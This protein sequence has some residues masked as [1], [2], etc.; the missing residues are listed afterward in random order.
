MLKR[1]YPS[2]ERALVSMGAR[3]LGEFDLGMMEQGSKMDSIG[4]S[5]Y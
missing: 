3:F 5:C 2:L 1:F 4:G